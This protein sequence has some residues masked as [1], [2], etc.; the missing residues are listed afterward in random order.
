[1][2]TDK[3]LVIHHGALGDALCAWPAFL[4]LAGSARTRW[5]APSNAA[6]HFLLPPLGYTPCPEELRSVE[7]AFHG[8]PI[9]AV[10][11]CPIVRFCLDKTPEHI[12]P[13]AICLTALPE[14]EMPVS[15]ALLAQLPGSLPSPEESRNAFQACFGAWKKENSQVGLFPGS[16]HRAKNWP[17]ERFVEAARLLERHGLEAVQILGPVETERGLHLP[18]I[19]ALIPESLAALSQILK[20]LRLTLACDGGPA[21]LAAWLGVPCVVLFGPSPA[22][23]WGPPGAR[24]VESPLACAPCSRTLHRLAC[25]QAAC[26]EALPVEQVVQAVLSLL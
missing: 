22:R 19:P 6:L 5:Y 10:E 12:P 26:M 17:P 25:G 15:D 1:M 7:D 9:P 11:E 3:L 8:G 23:R 2:P 16:G 24:I 20:G 14:E 13:G 4:A 21:H 18:D